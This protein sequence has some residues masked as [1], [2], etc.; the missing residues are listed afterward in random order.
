MP[1]LHQAIA[2]PRAKKPACEAKKS[3]RRTCRLHIFVKNL[4][5]LKK[6][7]TFALTFELRNCFDLYTSINSIAAIFETFK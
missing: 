2:P 3:I 6:I 4:R 7:F 5:E 1:Q